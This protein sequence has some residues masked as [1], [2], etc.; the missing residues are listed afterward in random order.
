MK[1]A[2]WLCGI[3]GVSVRLKPLVQI[4]PLQDPAFFRH[5]QDCDPSFLNFPYGEYQNPR[6][7]AFLLLAVLPLIKVNERSDIV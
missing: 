2:S 1:S 3:A 7:S 6:C 5:L 4:H